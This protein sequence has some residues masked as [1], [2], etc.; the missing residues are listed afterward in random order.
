[1]FDEVVGKLWLVVVVVVGV[2]WREVEPVEEVELEAEQW[3]KVVAELS[4]EVVKGVVL[5]P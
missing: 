5:G 4:Q 3:R 1:M 2:Q